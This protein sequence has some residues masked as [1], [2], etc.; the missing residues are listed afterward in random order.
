LNDF[1]GQVSLELIITTKQQI[2]IDGQNNKNAC[3]MACRT[4]RRQ[5]C[6]NYTTSHP[7]CT[8]KPGGMQFA[9]NKSE[10]ISLGGDPNSSICM[11]I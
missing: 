2:N 3:W 5:N 10:G 6:S 7:D 9:A 4:S 1:N 8:I 11:Y